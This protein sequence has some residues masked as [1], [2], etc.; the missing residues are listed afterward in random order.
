MAAPLASS[1]FRRL[2]SRGLF[3]SAAF[4]FGGLCELPFFCADASPHLTMYLVVGKSL[5]LSAAVHVAP[6]LAIFTPPF[7]MENVILH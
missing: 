1:P 4:L 2:T 7:G 5:K 3:F 6:R